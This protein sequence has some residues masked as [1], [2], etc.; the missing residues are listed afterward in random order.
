[1]TIT[2]PDDVRLSLAHDAT[3]AARQDLSA[4]SLGAVAPESYPG[5]LR[6]QDRLIDIVNAAFERAPGRGRDHRWVG[7]RRHRR[8]PPQRAQG[9][10][11]RH[12]LPGWRVTLGP[13]PSRTAGLSR[14]PG[15]HH[16]PNRHDAHGGLP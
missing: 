16:R 8:A 9:R 11:L 15:R 12:R 7:T 14:H 5:K 2:N 10:P 1:M 6:S 4:L 13:G 3:D